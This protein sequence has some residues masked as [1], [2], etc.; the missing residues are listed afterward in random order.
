MSTTVD[1]PEGA[2][3]AFSL[4]LESQERLLGLFQRVMAGAIADRGAIK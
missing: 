2:E 1:L 3:T 4:D